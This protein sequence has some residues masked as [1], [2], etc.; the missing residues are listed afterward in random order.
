MDAG[1]VP[2]LTSQLVAEYGDLLPPSLIASTV[3]AAASLPPAYPEE[4]DLRTRA[5][6]DVAALADARQRSGTTGR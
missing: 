6:D 2:A 5:R 1:D 4:P 3:E